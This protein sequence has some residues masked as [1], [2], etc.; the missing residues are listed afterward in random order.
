[1]I[2]ESDVRISDLMPKG[3]PARVPGMSVD[4]FSPDTPYTHM[5]QRFDPRAGDGA[6][7]ALLDTMAADGWLLVACIA[8]RQMTLTGLQ[9][10]PVY[11]LICRREGPLP[12]Y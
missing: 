10:E 2:A 4:P 7:A 12:G 5:V 3:K 9:P 6:L 11:Q 1:M 8:G